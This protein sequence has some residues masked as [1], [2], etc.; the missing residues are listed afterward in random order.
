MMTPTLI[1]A[2]IVAA[3]V[4]TAAVVTTINNRKE[5]ALKRGKV[6][7]KRLAAQEIS[8]VWGVDPAFS[9]YESEGDV[10]AIGWFVYG[11]R[12]VPLT[13]E[14]RFFISLRATGSSQC[15]SDVS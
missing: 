13:N 3:I 6:C 4:A 2:C 8:H 11:S 14:A 1:F 15:A 7:I 9:P 10:L 5:A 12:L